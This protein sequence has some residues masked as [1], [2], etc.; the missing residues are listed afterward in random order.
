MSV[1]IEDVLQSAMSLTLEQ[2]EELIDRLLEL[3]PREGTL[4]PA[5]TEELRRR[6]AELDSGEVKPIPWEEVRRLAW[7][8]VSHLRRDVDG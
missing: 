3:A 2:R 4:H 7:Q 1:T 5:W 6:S 8:R